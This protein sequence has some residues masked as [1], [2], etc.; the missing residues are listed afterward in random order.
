MFLCLL[1]GNMPLDW[2]LLGL[3]WWDMYVNV[4]LYNGCTAAAIATVY[5][6]ASAAAT[7]FIN[8]NI[9]KG[10]ILM[11]CNIKPH[12]NKALLLLHKGQSIKKNSQDGN[13]ES[14]SIT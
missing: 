14:V 6:T 12:V 5:I 9:K 3:W 7:Y 10:R 8:E 1:Y 11:A 13:N 4:L 2:N